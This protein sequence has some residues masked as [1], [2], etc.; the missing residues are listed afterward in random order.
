MKQ[1]FIEKVEDKYKTTYLGHSM[2]W[3]KIDEAYSDLR[4]RVNEELEIV[5]QELKDATY[6]RKNDT[7]YLYTRVLENLISKLATIRRQ[8]EEI[9]AEKK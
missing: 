9:K 8:V 5:L 1:I 4:Q 6:Y 7:R 3:S 2:L